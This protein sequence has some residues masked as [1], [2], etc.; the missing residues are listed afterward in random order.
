MKDDYDVVMVDR[1]VSPISAE[2]DT[3]SSGPT[4]LK[5]NLFTFLIKRCFNK[6]FD[7]L[8]S[9]ESEVNSLNVHTTESGNQVLEY[10]SIISGN[11]NKLRTDEN[12]T[13]VNLN[14]DMQ[15][16]NEREGM[17]KFLIENS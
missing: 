16:K 7:N 8:Q 4:S 3:H 15:E 13:D 1:N 17:K 2:N 5:V 14:E 11:P 6:I 9:A 10:P 12:W